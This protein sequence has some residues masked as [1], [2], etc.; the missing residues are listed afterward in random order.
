MCGI[1][2]AF[3]TKIKNKPVEDVNDFII[4]QFENQHARG[5]K[6]F[7]IIRINEKQNIEIDRSCETTKFLLDLYLKKSKMIIAHHRTPTSTEN[8]LGQT[9]PMSISNDILEFDYEIIHNG[10]I[11]NTDD[12]YKKHKELGFTYKTEMFEYGYG[13]SIR[14]K[15]NDSESIAVELALFIEKKTSAIGTDNNAAFIVLQLNKKTHKAVKVFFGRNGITSALTMFKV[16]GSLRIS[17]EGEGDE[18]EENQLYSF[19]IKDKKMQLHKRKIEFKKKEIPAIEDKEEKTTTDSNSL[20]KNLIVTNGNQTKTKDEEITVKV[21]REWVDRD[22]DDPTEEAPISSNEIGKGYVQEL[23]ASFKDK[24]KV[25]DSNAIT[26]IIDDSLDEEVGKITDILSDYK[27][28]L[29]NEKF[30]DRDIFFYSSQIFRIVKAMKE[31]TDI[32]DQDYGE[33]LDL[34]EELEDYNGSNPVGY[35]SEDWDGRTYE[36]REKNKKQMGFLNE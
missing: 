27:T 19:D 11:S 20:T 6:G 13:D 30:E 21:L 7:G 15:W 26:H 33:K 32:A 3:N 17:S 9:H 23:S 22:N 29:I 10:M 36:E 5:Q 1:L 28:A 14:T 8:L 25:E 2:G 16:K 4:N 34:E 12:L 31:I 24:I 35:L 18:V